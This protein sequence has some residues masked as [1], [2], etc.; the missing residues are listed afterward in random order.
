[1][2]E[3]KGLLDLRFVKDDVGR[4]Y[5]FEQALREIFPWDFKPPLA[6]RAPGEQIDAFYEWNSWHFLMEAK[7]KRGII[8]RGSHDWEDFELK[9]RKRRGACIGLFVS[10][11][12]VSK[13]VL[14]S[15][16]ELNEQGMTTIVLAGEL[17]DKLSETHIP[18]THLFRY[19]VL[20]AKGPTINN[21][22]I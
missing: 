11:F 6:M 18:L 17:W 14:E 13:G 21:F 5:L 7:A 9:I 1:M 19:L 10:L 8:Q 2:N 15:A 3:I 20:H 12:E 4:G 16:K 22:A